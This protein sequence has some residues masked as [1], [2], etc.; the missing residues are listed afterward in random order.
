MAKLNTN[1]NTAKQPQPQRIQKPNE[2]LKS[3]A[4]T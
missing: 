1:Q 3:A 4:I 2:Q